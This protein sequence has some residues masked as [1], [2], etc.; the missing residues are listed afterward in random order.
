MHLEETAVVGKV[1]AGSADTTHI[2]ALELWVGGGM[3]VLHALHSQLSIKFKLCVLVLRERGRQKGAACGVKT[4][5]TG[6]SLELVSPMRKLGHDRP[7]A[8][9]LRA[10]CSYGLDVSTNWA[11]AAPA[12]LWAFS[13]P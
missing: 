6:Q 1:V 10:G 4:Y 13:S 8:V 7:A 12:L 2:V 9:T 3:G 11:F 5:R